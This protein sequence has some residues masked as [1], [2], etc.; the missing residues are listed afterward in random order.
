MTPDEVTA[1]LRAAGCVFAED[2]AA[3]LLAAADSPADLTSMVKQRVAGRP[4]EY[5]VG[6]VAFGG[7]RIHIADGVFVPRRRTELLAVRAADLMENNQILVDM[8]CG[9]GAVAA[10]VTDTVPTARVIACDVDPVATACARRNLPHA[11]VFTGDLFTVLPD[12]IIGHIDVLAANAPYVPTL[13]IEM[14]P[15]EARDHEPTATLDGGTDGL[16]IARRIVAG[17]PDRLRPGGHLLIE[18]STRQAATL[19]DLMTEQGFR[20]RVV[21]DDDIGGTVVIGELP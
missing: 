3:I 7:L 16:D 11:D 12:S 18:T 9:A 20:A 6:W 15:R 5:I 8:C 4:L 19:T 13:D 2:E 17:A 10:F 21:T 1:T 14:M